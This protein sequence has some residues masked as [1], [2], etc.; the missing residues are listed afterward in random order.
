[1][2]TTNL[3]LRHQVIRI[4]KELLYLSRDYP[5]GYDWARSRLHKAFSSQA[6]LKDEEAIRNGIKR[7]EFVRKEIE[8]L[9]YLKRYR[10]LRQ[11][12]DPIK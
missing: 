6:H 2:S 3:P 12:Y 8:A 5:Q 1:M 10:A 4:Y 9:Y 11:R 7:A